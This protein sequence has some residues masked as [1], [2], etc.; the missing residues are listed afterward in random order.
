VHALVDSATACLLLPA[1]AYAIFQRLSTKRTHRRAGFALSIVGLIE[2]FEVVIPKSAW[3]RHFDF[4]PGTL[5]PCVHASAD[6][7]LV[8]GALLFQHWLVE[9]D[10]SGTVGAAGGYPIIG[11]G[12]RRR[13]Y[14]LMRS[15]VAS[16]R[17]ENEQHIER[18][19][20]VNSDGMQFFANISVGHPPQHLTVLVATGANT[21]VLFCPPSHA[22]SASDARSRASSAYAALRPPAPTYTPSPAHRVM[23]TREHERGLGGAGCMDACHSQPHRPDALPLVIAST[24]TVGQVLGSLRHTLYPLWLCFRVRAPPRGLSH[25]DR[26][27]SRCW[28]F[29][30][31]G[32]CRYRRKRTSHH[33]RTLV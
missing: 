19:A 21:L 13:S 22:A 14:A 12:R 31:C 33:L 8:I 17:G 2:T 16:A 20:L 23:R 7:T 29:E 9:F 10:L 26:S 30:H 1:H 11:F 32:P 5:F 28:R 25:S 6:D 3:A 27:S 15:G 18:V 24:A 4:A